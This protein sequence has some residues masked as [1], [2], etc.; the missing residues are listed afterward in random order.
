MEKAN[1]LHI[2]CGKKILEGYINLDLIDRGQEVVGDVF[3]Y[4]AEGHDEEFDEV[5]AEHFVEHF[6]PDEVKLLLGMVHGVLKPG[7][8]FHIV[9]PHKDKDAAFLL[10]HKTYFTA[11]TFIKLE[12]PEFCEDYGIPLWEID[13]LV[14]NDRKD[15]HCKLVKPIK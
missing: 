14:V 15:I 12:D 4:L 9:V 11:Y 6:D 2:G 3:E 8:I 7:G 1:K 10:S 13:T 5:K